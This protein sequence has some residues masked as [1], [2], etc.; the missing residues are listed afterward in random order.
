MATCF[1]EALLKT[2]KWNSEVGRNQKGK[3]TWS[4]RD[5]NNKNERKECVTVMLCATRELKADTVSEK[6]IKSSDTND[7]TRKTVK[8]PLKKILI[9]V[10]F[11]IKKRQWR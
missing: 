10:E 1:V 9:E 4:E 11:A 2:P 7:R 8:S 3:E 6:L 5:S